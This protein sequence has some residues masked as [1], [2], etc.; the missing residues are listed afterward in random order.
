MDSTNNELDLLTAKEVADTLK[1]NPQ[2][3]LRKLQAGE[4]PGYKIGKEWRI[5]RSKLV[6]WLERHSNQR[7]HYPNR[8]ADPFFND[9]GTLKSIPA[10]RKKRIAVLEVLLANFEPNRVYPEKELNEIIRRFHSDFCTI[11]REFILEKMMVR[12]QGNYMANSSYVSKYYGRF[13]PTIG[14]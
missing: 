1:M 11:R 6:D 5:N 13:K 12:N 8:L 3:V 10:Q 2:V 4:I 9:D 7:K 14:I